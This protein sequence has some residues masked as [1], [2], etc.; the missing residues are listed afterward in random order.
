MQRNLE[1][2][3]ALAGVIRAAVLVD[4]VG[5]YGLLADTDLQS[6]V[7]SLFVTDPVQARDIF[8]EL[9]S[10][11]KGINAMITLFSNAGNDSDVNLMRYTVSMLYLERRLSNHKEMLQR[12]SHGIDTAKRQAEHY[13]DTHPNVIAN[14]AGLYSDTISEVG[15]RIMVSGE[16]HHL[17]IPDNA[18]RIRTLLLSGIRSAVLWRQIGGRR[19]HLLFSRKKYLTAAEE[20]L[21]MMDRE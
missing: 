19:W 20:L 17:A 16:E 12:L 7:K 15:P 1:Q 11:K 13:T 5:R 4:D 18:N 8:G 21:K 14:L 2:A 10:L 6:C 3:M 9:A